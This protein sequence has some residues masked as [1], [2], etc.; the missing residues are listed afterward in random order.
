MAYPIIP[1]LEWN[2]KLLIRISP[3]T[4]TAFLNENVELGLLPLRQFFQYLAY[5]YNRAFPV[6]TALS[7]LLL[8]TDGFSYR[9][10]ITRNYY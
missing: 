6:H 1:R 9:V 5:E 4:Y 3:N 10:M 2:T 8:Q 7:I